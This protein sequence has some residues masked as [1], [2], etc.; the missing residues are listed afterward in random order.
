MKQVLDAQK[1]IQAIRHNIPVNIKTYTLPPEIE[2]QIEQILEIYLKDIGQIK[3]KDPLVYSLKELTA[4]AQ[5]ANAK[6]AFLARE[7]SI[8][9][10]QMTTKKE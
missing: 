8:W 9:K 5:K 10:T 7:S 6:R 3:V 1:V 2:A 4:N